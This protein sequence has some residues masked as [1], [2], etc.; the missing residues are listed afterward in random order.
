MSKLSLIGGLPNPDP[1]KLNQARSGLLYNRSRINNN[2]NNNNT[3]G[4]E[5]C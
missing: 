3:S 5:Q 2:N 1:A 4:A